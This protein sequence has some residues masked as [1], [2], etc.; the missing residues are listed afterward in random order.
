M[1]GRESKTAN[2]R[3]A[4]CKQ[5]WGKDGEN[6]NNNRVPT[7][8]IGYER[9]LPGGI[10]RQE[11]VHREGVTETNKYH[12]KGDTKARGEFAKKETMEKT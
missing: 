11:K 3:K 1:K 2:R 12:R 5:R 6:I 8:G 9:L 7:L 4:H 10:N